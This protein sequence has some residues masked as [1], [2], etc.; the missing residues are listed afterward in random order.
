MSSN[1]QSSASERAPLM[2]KSFQF[3]I[4]SVRLAQTLRSRHNEYGLAKQILGSG[5]AIG[6]LIREAQRAESKPDFAHKM[7]IALKEAEET[8]YWLELLH[9]T[10]YLND[11]EFASLEADVTELIRMLTATVKTAR[12]RYN[13][14]ND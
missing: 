10:D 12:S 5:T 2:S 13:P 4:R 14:S 11:R 1:G 9:A 3:A 6:A 7:N 8:Q